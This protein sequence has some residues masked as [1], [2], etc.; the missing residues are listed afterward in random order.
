MDV[1]PIV[2]ALDVREQVGMKSVPTTSTSQKRGP[3]DQTRRRDH[4]YKTISEKIVG[5]GLQP[6]EEKGEARPRIR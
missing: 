4:R 2:V 3:L 5:L 1:L 6:A